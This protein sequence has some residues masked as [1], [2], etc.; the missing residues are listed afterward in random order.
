[1][2]FFIGNLSFLDLC[3]SSVYIP[4]IL[5]NCISEDKSIS[6]AGCAAQFFASAGSAGIECYLLAAMAYD[7]HVAISNPLLYNAVMSKKLCMGLVAASYLNGFANSILTT[8]L[9]FNLSS[10]DSSI[11]DDFFCGLT[12]VVKLS[13]DVTDSCQLLLYFILTYNVIIPSALIL[14]SYAS[15]LVAVLKMHSSMGQRKAFST[16]ATHLVSITIY[17]GSILFIYARP[18]SSFVGGNKV[19]SVFYTVVIPML[20]PFIYSLR[21]QEVRE[22]L[23][24]L[25]RR[26]PAS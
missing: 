23:K 26:Q 2:Y 14:T 15:I 22:A 10:C 3:Y 11:I 21:N 25:M 24:R 18:S 6:F 5:L 19:V 12:P 9:T 1:M 16:C 13:C 17:Y 20:N 8:S 4:K 7:R